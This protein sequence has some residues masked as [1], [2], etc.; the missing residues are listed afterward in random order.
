MEKVKRVLGDILRNNPMVLNEPAWGIWFTEFADSSLNL[1]IKYWI[2][3]Y[4]QK[5]DITDQINME[6]KRR[7][8]EEGI[9]IPFPQRDVH[10]KQGG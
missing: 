10:I 7:F 6:I 3:D 1:F 5:F 8:E 2:S 4:R 9:E